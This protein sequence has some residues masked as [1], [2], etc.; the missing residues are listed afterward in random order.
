MY[1]YTSLAT[2]G[3]TSFFFRQGRIKKQGGQKKKQVGQN[4]ARRARKIFLPPLFYFLPPRQNSILPLG[5]N[6]QQ[7]GQKT[8]LYL[9]KEGETLNNRSLSKPQ[10]TVLFFMSAM[11]F[12]IGQVIDIL[13]S[14]MN[15]FRQN[16][17]QRKKEGITLHQHVKDS[18]LV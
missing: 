11:H 17:G 16:E 3:V 8:L 9:E 6:R 1:F 18:N 10:L 12:L 5:Q 14:Q 15:T 13:I 7:G 4:R 2:R